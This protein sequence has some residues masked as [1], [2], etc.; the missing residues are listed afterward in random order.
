MRE[1]GAP[2]AAALAQRVLSRDDGLTAVTLIEAASPS[3]ETE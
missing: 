1:T 3:A 2:S